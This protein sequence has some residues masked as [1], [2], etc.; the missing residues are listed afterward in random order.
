MK[1]RWW[2]I[3]LL[4]GWAGLA[5]GWYVYR[6]SA[7][8]EEVLLPDGRRI[9]VHQR[10]DLIE[11]Y[12]TRRTWLRFSLPEMGGEQVW[13]EWLYP[14][15]IGAADGKVYVIGRAPG[16]KEFRMYSDPRYMYVAYQWQHDRFVRI[17]FMSV[18]ASA[19]ERAL[20]PS[21][22]P[23]FTRAC[24]GPGWGLV[25]LAC[26]ADPERPIFRQTTGR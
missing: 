12:G 14:T 9:A 7:W 20:V 3:A 16:G 10:R 8:T 24:I 2:L 6:F 17:P 15:M 1:R 11:G 5:Y 23:R 25:Q 19:R 4:L 18:A 22:R 21:G 26:T 13:S